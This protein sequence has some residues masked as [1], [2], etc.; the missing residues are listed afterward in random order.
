MRTP[1][2]NGKFVENV[3]LAIQYAPYLHYSI[4]YFFVKTRCAYNN[5]SALT[6]EWTDEPTYLL[7][8]D[9]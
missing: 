3:R 6:P 7:V 2:C 9:E 8:L 4:L 1:N 5:R